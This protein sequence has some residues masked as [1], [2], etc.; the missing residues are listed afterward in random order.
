MFSVLGNISLVVR[1][2]ENVE[3]LSSNKVMDS[4]LMQ[5]S[6]SLPFLIGFLLFVG[7]GSFFLDKDH[8]IRPFLALC[9]SAENSPP[10]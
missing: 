2:L 7:I 3:H 6:P 8:G 4:F 5:I 9:L 10:L 1:P